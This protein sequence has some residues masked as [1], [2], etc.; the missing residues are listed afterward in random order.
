MFILW[1]KCYTLFYKVHLA[2]DSGKITLSSRNWL[3]PVQVQAYT[4]SSA[5]D[6]DKQSFSFDGEFAR[7]W[8][9]Q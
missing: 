8:I 2:L 6:I 3:T 7:L 1:S 4:P 5:H 9:Q